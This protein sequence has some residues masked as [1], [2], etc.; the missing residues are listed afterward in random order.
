LL[1]IAGQGGMGT[2]YRA[3]QASP[4]RIVAVKVLSQAT[5]SPDKLAAFQHEAETIARLEHPGI[6]P[7]Y[8]F[9]EADGR[10]YLVL[11]YLSGGSVAALIRKGPIAAGQAARW[12]RSMAEA[13]AF[14][15]AHGLVHRDVKPSNMLLDEAGNAYL[16]DFGIAAASDAAGNGP[17][18]GSATAIGS[19]AYMSPEQGSGRPTDQR[20]DLYSLAVSLFEMVTGQPPYTAE[21]PLGVIV[22][23]INDPI[24]SARALNPDVPRALDAFIQRGMAK[25]PAGRPQT[26]AEFVR[27]L[28]QA[29]AAPNDAGPD[30]SAAEPPATLLGPAPAAAPAQRSPSPVLWVGIG[31]AAIC[32]LGALALGGGG[33]LYALL[34]APRTSATPLPTITPISEPTLTNSAPAVPN[35][36]VDFATS[37]GSFGLRAADDSGGITYPQ[38]Q[39]RFSVLQSG[40][41]F[42]STS[43]RVRAQDVRLEVDTQQTGQPV[44][45]EFGGICRW[46]DASHFI[47][48]AIG[49]DGNFKIWQRSGDNIQRLIDWTYLPALAGG[50]LAPHHLTILCAGPQL[51]L[52]VDGGAPHLTTDPNPLPGD[53][54]VFAGL[55]AAGPLTVDF[56]KVSASQP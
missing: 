15:H 3:E 51:S 4:R 43:G 50:E 37:R 21:T 38:G 31:L 29:L 45:S 34:A 39:L 18:S 48:F 17:S 7:V 26:A 12:T 5:A 19:A 40:A 8:G 6:L 54:A 14:A 22:R 41:E 23:H 49:S 32:L 33:A 52:S 36:S 53:I 20:S 13:L 56:T 35:L 30:V 24:P 27:L 25:N 46:Q 11:R 9:G 1:A 2:V 28:D 55:R 42:F 10:P 16:T 44:L 47:A